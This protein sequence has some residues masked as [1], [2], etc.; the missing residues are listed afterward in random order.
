VVH[1]DDRGRV[2][3]DKGRTLRAIRNILSA[4]AG[5]RRPP[6][7]SSSSTVAPKARSEDVE[8]GFVS[9][10]F[11]FRGEVRLHLH[12]PSS[13]LLRTPRAVVLV[14]PDG[15][16][17][18]VTMSARPGAGKRVLG[19]IAGVTDEHQAAALKDF[20]V[21]IPRDALPAPEEGEFYVAD[22]VGLA[23]EA[24]DR[25]GTIREIHQAG[26]VDVLEVEVG[27]KEPVF[28][29]LVEGTVVDVDLDGGIVRLAEG[30]LDDVE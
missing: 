22:L 12:N 1:P 2:D 16:R 28:V 20:R 25:R 13:D 14:A 11:G 7:T 27:G 5:G 10:V 4:A 8:L 29:P 21:L 19:R 15:S 17:R 26:P 23:V 24:G 6:S 9:G 18:T 30:S 3:G